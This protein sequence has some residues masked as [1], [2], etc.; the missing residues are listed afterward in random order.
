[1][2][3]KAQLFAV[4]LAIRVPKGFRGV[5][6]VR[7]LAKKKEDYEMVLRRGLDFRVVKVWKEGQEFWAEVEIVGLH[8]S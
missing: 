3:R 6:F 5:A 4:G 2:I 1:M 8:F 7:S